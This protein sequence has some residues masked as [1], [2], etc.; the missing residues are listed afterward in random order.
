MAYVTDAKTIPAQGKK[1]L[2]NL[3]LL[4]LNAL[5]F[6]HHETHLNIEE[7]LAL[8]EE[9]KPRRTYLTHISH[10]MGLHA[11]AEAIL[12]PSVHLGYDGLKLKVEGQ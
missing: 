1:L 8:I 5:R 12:P 9:L 11:E 3:D 7:A 2:Q 10:D 4:I 6:K